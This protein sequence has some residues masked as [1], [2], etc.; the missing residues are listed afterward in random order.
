MANDYSRILPA[1]LTLAA[2]QASSEDAIKRLTNSLQNGLRDLLKSTRQHEYSDEQLL[3]RDRNEHAKLSSLVNRLESGLRQAQVVWQHMEKRMMVQTE[4]HEDTTNAGHRTCHIDLMRQLVERN[5]AI[6]ELQ[7]QLQLTTEDYA[8]KIEDIRASILKDGNSARNLLEDAVSELQDKLEERLNLA[9]EHARRLGDQSKTGQATLENQLKEAQE[10]L[11]QVAADAAT[12]NE[13]LQMELINERSNVAE[14]TG[15][16]MAFEEGAKANAMLCQRWNQDIRAADSMRKQLQALSGRLPQMENLGEKLDK[17]A[18]MNGVIH[19]TATYLADERDWVH[20]QLKST[21]RSMN[22][23]TDTEDI[24][25]IPEAITLAPNADSAD[26]ASQKVKLD[27]AQS[28]RSASVSMI[29]V[30]SLGDS[31]R[32][33]VTV[34]SPN[35]ADDYPFPPPSVEQEQARRRAATRPRSI[36]K[37]SLSSVP[38]LREPDEQL[39]GAPANHSQYNRPVCGGLS[40]AAHIANGVVKQIRSGFIRQPKPLRDWS[41]PTVAD[42]ERDCQPRKEDESLPAPVSGSQELTGIPGTKRERQGESEET[43]D[44]AK[45]AKSTASLVTGDHT[46]RRITRNYG[47]TLHD[48]P[49]ELKP[50]LV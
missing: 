48:Q 29:D 17:I 33:R 44:R 5:E 10:N 13:K 7:R 14:L 36:L 42:F 35:D 18:C 25:C 40:S 4:T 3:T 26:T 28:Q 2:T 39:L 15:K 22:V 12:N 19:S 27:D 8:G 11:V 41:F 20:K 47:R 24:S 50:V 21:L 34:H 31:L 37:F 45:F 49:Q 46:G 23:S 38:G 32:R 6:S 16:A 43:H 30:T 1:V 9:Q